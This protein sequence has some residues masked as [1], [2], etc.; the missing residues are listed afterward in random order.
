M[1]KSHDGCNLQFN[2]PAKKGKYACARLCAEIMNVK[3]ED[4]GGKLL[5]VN[6]SR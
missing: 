5:T 1:L 3:A 2:S 4:K 6:Q